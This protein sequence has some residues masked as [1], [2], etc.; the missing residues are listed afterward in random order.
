MLSNLAKLRSRAL[1]F[2]SS[3][4]DLNDDDNLEDLNAL[5]T[6]LNKEDLQA[7]CKQSPT[8]LN[9][10]G[11]LKRRR[12]KHT[13]QDYNE[14]AN[15]LSLQDDSVF[16]TGIQDAP[17]TTAELGVVDCLYSSNKR[18][19]DVTELKANQNNCRIVRRKPET[20]NID[21]V[22][23]D[24]NRIVREQ[25]II[26][27][28]VETKK[29]EDVDEYTQTLRSR[30]ERRENQRRAIMAKTDTNMANV[31]LH[32]L[33]V[34]QQTTANFNDGALSNQETADKSTIE[35]DQI[36]SSANIMANKNAKENSHYKKFV[37]KLQSHFKNS[38]TAFK[39]H[40][41][42]TDSG[43]RLQLR[44]NLRYKIQVQQN[45]R[46]E[47][48]RQMLES[49][50][51]M[52]SEKIDKF[53]SENFKNDLH[54]DDNSDLDS[55]A[56]SDTKTEEAVENA[57]E[58]LRNLG[59]DDE[60]KPEVICSLSDQWTIQ[61]LS[62]KHIDDDYAAGVTTKNE[63]DEP[64][65]G[66]NED[67][68]NE[69]DKTDYV[70]N[71]I[72]QQRNLSQTE[73][74]QQSP[75]DT[76]SLKGKTYLASDAEDDQASE[77]EFVADCK[78]HSKSKT[79]CVSSDESDNERESRNNLHETVSNINSDNDH[80]DFEENVEPSMYRSELGS[81]Y[82]QNASVQHFADDFIE[83]QAE[84]SGSEISADDEED[85]TNLYDEHLDI[86]DTNEDLLDDDVN[87]TNRMH[88]MREIA[89]DE[90]KVKALRERYLSKLQP[91]RKRNFH[92]EDDIDFVNSH[93]SEQDDLSD[94]SSQSSS[95]LS[96][97]HNTDVSAISS[98][99]TS[100]VPF[101]E[102]SV[103]RLLNETRFKN[104]AAT[105]LNNCD[106][107]TL[108]ANQRSQFLKNMANNLTNLSKFNLAESE[109][110]NFDP[111]I[112]GDNDN[113][114]DGMTDNTDS[115]FKH[116]SK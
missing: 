27:P 7:V 15:L 14:E 18:K 11:N 52:T 99:R 62:D 8:K 114:N 4:N 63:V 20:D 90:E 74:Y 109:Y 57:F 54:N 25:P 72:D 67:K 108:V 49:T 81:V 86:I 80:S 44:E 76:T 113:A 16:E 87:E 83:D 70:L 60:Q 71:W 95:M 55:I 56:I 29:I 21:G 37:N 28:T 110:F 64:F 77:V 92:W 69:K 116:F 111:M 59:K 48:N 45:N 23:L 103:D 2:S 68:E 115:V 3:V 91:S 107:A 30:K 1:S 13:F 89:D 94:T 6:V 33:D 73:I 61:S 65:I 84:I 41:N 96:V 17:T 40:D 66:I 22:M 24:V 97:L 102:N 31:S 104:P 42:L 79:L 35:V 51:H 58:A 9:S 75:E 5:E 34:H 39:P 26:L 85:E 100:S 38:T 98:K 105:E 47:K 112:D 10:P 19:R 93:F 32:W 36:N 78:G 12:K 82:K 106:T 43:S 88:I 46:Y 53:V 50:D 101:F